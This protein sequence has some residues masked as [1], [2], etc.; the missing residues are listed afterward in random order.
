MKTCPQMDLTNASRVTVG[1]SS[2]EK[3]WRNIIKSNA[4]RVLSELPQLI[5]VTV[6]L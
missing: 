5:I 2:L 4:V 1:S 3:N 6:T